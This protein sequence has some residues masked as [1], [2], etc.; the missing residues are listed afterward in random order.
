MIGDLIGGSRP[1]TERK[2]PK[3]YSL[4]T[5]LSGPEEAADLAE[6]WELANEKGANCHV[7][8]EAWVADE[9]PTPRAA[10][11]MCA[12]CPI[13]AQCRAYAEKHNPACGVWG[14]VP[15]NRLEEETNE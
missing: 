13:I 8:P 6:L 2:T 14:G 1:G 3:Q 4:R 15:Y 7:D 9:L 11:A 10:Q 12:S 5:L